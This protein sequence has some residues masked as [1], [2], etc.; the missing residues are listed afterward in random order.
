MRLEAGSAGVIH[1]HGELISE[2]RVAEVGY[3]KGIQPL[4]CACPIGEVLRE[5]AHQ[6]PDFGGPVGGQLLPPADH[7]AQFRRHVVHSHSVWRRETPRF[8]DGAARV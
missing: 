2:C 1:H 5:F 6:W 8:G 3:G 7:P 4:L